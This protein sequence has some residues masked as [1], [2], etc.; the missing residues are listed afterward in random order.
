VDLKATLSNLEATEQQFLVILEK[1][2]TV[3]DILN[4]QKELSRVQGEIEQTKARMQY[5]EQTSSTSII[6][7]Q[8]EESTIYFEFSADKRRGVREGEEITF[9]VSSI[10]GGFA[11]YAFLWDFGDGQTSTDENPTH[12]YRDDGYYDVSLAVTDDEGNTETVTR[13][14]YVYVQPGWNAGGMVGTAWDGL[15]TFGHVLANVFIWIGIFSPVWLIAGGLI[16]WRVRRRRSR[17][18]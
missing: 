13:D 14:S 3:E 9:T 8:L 5:L 15:V 4:V 7:V 6:Y 11:P 10:S 17:N 2:E 16:F 1:A 18:N 12:S